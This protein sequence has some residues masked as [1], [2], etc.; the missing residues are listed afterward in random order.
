[1]TLKEKIL[2][3]LI[4]GILFSYLNFLIIDKFIVETSIY[5]YIF[6]EIILVLSIKLFKFTKHLLNLN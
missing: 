1:M 6:I 5:Q 4:L 3:S 2:N